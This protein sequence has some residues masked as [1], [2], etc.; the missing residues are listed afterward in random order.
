MY[1]S[2]I[3]D[4]NIWNQATVWKLFVFILVITSDYRQISAMKH[5]KRVII[6]IDHLQTNKISALNDLEGVDMPLSE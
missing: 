3:L 5:W 1:E 2:L 4:K 6:T